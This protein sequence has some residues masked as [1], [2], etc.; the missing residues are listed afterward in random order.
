MGQPGEA[1]GGKA[2]CFNLWW[3]REWKA[4]Q[5]AGVESESFFKGM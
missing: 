2:L 5:I 1:A 3:R 4:H